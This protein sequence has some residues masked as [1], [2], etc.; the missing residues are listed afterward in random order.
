MMLE[1]VLS[2]VP[3]A[4]SARGGNAREASGVAGWSW[5]LGALPSF[6]T[7]PA[8]PWGG[9]SKKKTHFRKSFAPGLGRELQRHLGE[10]AR[11]VCL[12]ECG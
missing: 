8:R 12:Y 10:V 9:T 6:L 3:L 2:T 11:G 1:I 5:T 7:I 4:L